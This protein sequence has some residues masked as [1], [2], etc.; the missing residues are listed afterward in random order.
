MVAFRDPARQ[1]GDVAI[2]LQAKVPDA[3]AWTPRPLA[4]RAVGVQ[5][6]GQRR[7]ADPRAHGT[8]DQQSRHLNRGFP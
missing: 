2:S 5:A 3:V 8:A 4:H 1:L 7:L 6:G